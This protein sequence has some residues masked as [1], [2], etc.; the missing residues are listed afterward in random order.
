ML[1]VLHHYTLWHTLKRSDAMHPM[2][3]F[4]QK[5]TWF[6]VKKTNVPS[7]DCENAKWHGGMPPFK[8]ND[9][10]H[11][12]FVTRTCWRFWYKNDSNHLYNNLGTDFCCNF[13]KKMLWSTKSN[14]QNYWLLLNL[15]LVLIIDKLRLSLVLNQVFHRLWAKKT[16]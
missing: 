5:Y 11:G 1:L 8:K 4:L 13:S 16:S 14:W 2:L 7:Q 3:I 9:C 12:K 6:L 10:E 15:L